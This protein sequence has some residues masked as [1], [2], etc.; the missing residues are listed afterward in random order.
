MGE[1]FQDAHGD[2]IMYFD[3]IFIFLH[4]GTNLPLFEKFI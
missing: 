4:T 2:V 1:G 3:A